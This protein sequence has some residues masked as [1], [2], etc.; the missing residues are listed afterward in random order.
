MKVIKILK[1]A[2]AILL[3]FFAARQMPSFC[4]KEFYL[5]VGLFDFG[6]LPLL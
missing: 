4:E 3:L 1:L 6:K 2:A 5:P